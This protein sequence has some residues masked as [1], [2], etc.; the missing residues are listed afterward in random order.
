MK[1][2]MVQPVASGVCEIGQSHSAEVQAAIVDRA[3]LGRFKLSRNICIR[4][5]MYLYIVCSYDICIQVR[6]CTGIPR[7]HTMTVPV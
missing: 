7:T 1:L 5:T 4:S 3:D 2:S 6:S